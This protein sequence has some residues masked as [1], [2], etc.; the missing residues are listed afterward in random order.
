MQ[1]ATCLGCVQGVGG[2]P[3]YSCSARR[4]VDICSATAAT[5]PLWKAAACNSVAQRAVQCVASR[6]PPMGIPGRGALNRRAS[7]HGVPPAPALA[8]EVQWPDLEPE[9]VLKYTAYT[10]CY[11]VP[12]IMCR[13]LLRLFSGLRVLPLDPPLSAR[14]MNEE[15]NSCAKLKSRAYTSSS[16]ALVTSSHHVACLCGMCELWRFEA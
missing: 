15:R 12:Q 16:V 6:P 9:L 4:P 7:Q 13:V 8:A 3:K 10:P 14:R 2:W 11:F 5:K 1:C